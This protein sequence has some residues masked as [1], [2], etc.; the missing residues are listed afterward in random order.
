M[1]WMKKRKNN[2]TA[3][4]KH[5]EKQH[6]I[7]IIHSIVG[8]LCVCVCVFRCACVCKSA[9]AMMTTRKWNDDNDWHT[10]GSIIISVFTIL[11][12]ICIKNVPQIWF[13]DQ[14]I[15]LFLAQIF[16]A[17]SFLRVCTQQP[18]SNAIDV[19][20]FW[21]FFSFHLLF[22][23]TNFIRTKISFHCGTDS[24]DVAVA[25]FSRLPLLYFMNNSYPTDS[26]WN[27]MD[28]LLYQ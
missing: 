7:E 25:F 9:A 19:V 28:F 8:A 3:Q 1:K 13:P 22:S 23:E 11:P 18:G 21:F 16:F 6:N 15:I 20:L 4:H 26:R 5:T 24:R 17:P 2:I 14:K 12:M 27:V 10:T